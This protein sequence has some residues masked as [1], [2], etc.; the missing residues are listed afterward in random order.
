MCSQE[1]PTREKSIGKWLQ[2]R[3]SSASL[4]IDARAC[5]SIGVCHSAIEL[6]NVIATQLTKDKVLRKSDFTWTV[7]WGKGDAKGAEVSVSYNEDGKVETIFPE[8]TEADR[9]IAALC[10]DLGHGPY[11]HMFEY[12]AKAMKSEQERPEAERWTHEEMSVKMLRHL[13]KE[14]NIDLAAYGLDPEKDLT[15]IEEMILGDDLPGGWKARKGRGPEKAFLYDIVNNVHSG[16]DVDKL[17]YFMRDTMCAL[18]Q[19][20][21]GGGGTHGRGVSASY[22]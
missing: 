9:I 16:L 4:I 20:P 1:L 18:G 10:H 8:I 11:S 7:W 3:D 5:C 14:N 13:L 6:L 17:D 21:W 15:F 19:V 2:L 22:R 12:V